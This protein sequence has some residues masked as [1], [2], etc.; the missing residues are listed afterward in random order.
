M[1]LIL[2]YFPRPTD[3]V[4]EYTAYAHITFQKSAKSEF[5]HICPLKFQKK[6]FRK[7]KK[8]IY[9]FLTSSQR[10]GPN[11]IHINNF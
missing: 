9:S 4:T 3:S 6:V 5:K 2:D 8:H 11:L 7:K 1:Y 10:Y